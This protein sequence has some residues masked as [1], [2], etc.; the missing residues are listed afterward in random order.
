MKVYEEAKKAFQD[1]LVPELRDIQVNIRRIGEKVNFYQKSP[2]QKIDFLYN[3]LIS[4]K[5]RIDNL[6][7]ELKIAIDIRERLAALEAKMGI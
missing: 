6:E 1:I 7:K 5:R 4:E 2:E 3:E